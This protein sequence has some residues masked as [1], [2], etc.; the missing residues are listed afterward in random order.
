MNESNDLKDIPQ[1]ERDAAI[2]VLKHYKSKLDNFDDNKLK[3]FLKTNFDTLTSLGITDLPTSKDQIDNISDKNQL[4]LIGAQ[5]KNKIKEQ[6][7]TKASDYKPSVDEN[8]KFMKKY[9]QLDTNDQTKLKEF[10]KN[11]TDKELIL[12]NRTRKGHYNNYF[13]TR[14]FILKELAQHN[15]SLEAAVDSSNEEMKLDFLVEH[16]KLL[17]EQVTDP[18]ELTKKIND[19]FNDPVFKPTVSKSIQNS[20]TNKETRTVTNSNGNEISSFNIYSSNYTNNPEEIILHITRERDSNNNTNTYK[21]YI[22]KDK[23]FNDSKDLYQKIAVDTNNDILNNRGELS[24]K[25]LIRVS[26]NGKKL[27]NGSNNTLSSVINKVYNNEEKATSNSKSTAW[28]QKIKNHIA[29]LLVSNSHS[30]YSQRLTRFQTRVKCFKS[31]KY[32]SACS[33]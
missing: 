3:D 10:T 31:S 6:L 8:Y 19:L 9:Y 1:A 13:I 4:I 2:T 21:V 20:S 16:L 32:S 23:F 17:K 22:D 15:L 28:H 14:D 5:A 27:M 30:Q 12:L 25:A 11:L 26:E 29:L 24:H 18:N 7:N 33:R